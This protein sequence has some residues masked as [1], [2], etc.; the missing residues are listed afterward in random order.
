[1]HSRPSHKSFISSRRVVS[2]LHSANFEETLSTECD[3]SSQQL[4]WCSCSFDKEI[5]LDLRHGM[6]CEQEMNSEQLTLV[7]CYIQV[8]KGMNTTQLYSEYY[9][10]S[11]KPL[12][13]PFWNNQYFM[14]CRRV[15]NV[16]QM[17]HA[18]R[19]TRND[20]NKSGLSSPG[21][22][23]FSYPSQ[24]APLKLSFVKWF[25]KTNLIPNCVLNNCSILTRF[26]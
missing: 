13:G 18:V 15:S 19:L 9:W 1:M 6:F 2:S 12:L 5:Q 10:V 20:P 7:F 26:T 21:V 14:E 3:I 24:H 23:L 4:V 22:Q 25:L 8:I 17:K 11:Y 16:A